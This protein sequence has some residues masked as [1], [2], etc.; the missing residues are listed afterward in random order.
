MSKKKWP[1]VVT[2]QPGYEPDQS[3]PAQQKFVWSYEITVTN[4]SEEIIQLL[5]RYWRITEMTG[6]I[7]EINGAGV[8]GLQPLIKPGKR[9]VYVSYCQ[10]TTPQGTMEGYY[11]MQDLEENHFE[12]EIPK[13]VLSAPTSIT[14]LYRSRL[15]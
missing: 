4:N 8:V 2:T 14:E 7:E 13:F 12:I 11:G 1:I 6:K 5:T 10:L 9:F 3:N 15:H